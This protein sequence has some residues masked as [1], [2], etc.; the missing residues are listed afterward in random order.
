[1]TGKRTCVLSGAVRGSGKASQ[2]SRARVTH[3]AYPNS[4]IPPGRGVRAVAG[5]NQAHLVCPAQSTRRQ[6]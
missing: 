2:K 1:M 4:F 6:P 3:E 5:V